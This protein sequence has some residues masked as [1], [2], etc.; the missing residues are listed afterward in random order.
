MN[1]AAM[2]LA[3]F[4]LRLATPIRTSAAGPLQMRAGG[5]GAG[6]EVCDYLWSDGNSDESVLQ[7]LWKQKTSPIRSSLSGSG[8]VHRY[9]WTT[10][11]ILNEQPPWR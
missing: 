7:D 2:R 4:R 8:L 1:L 6:A 5:A 10:S 11:S 3:G 9:S